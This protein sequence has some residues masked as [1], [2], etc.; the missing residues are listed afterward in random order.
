ME[1]FVLRIGHLYPEQ[2][3]LYGDRGN[4]LALVRRIQWRQIAVEVVAIDVGSQ[5]DWDSLAMVFM[6]GGEDS[7]QVHIAQD[8]LD[9]GPDLLP[10]I[11]QGMPMLAICGAYQLLGSEYVTNDG[12]HLPGLGFLDVRTE[13]GKSRQIGDVVCQVE[14]VSLSPSTLVGFENHGGMT[15]LG[16]EATAL[17]RVQTGSGNNGMDGT[18][19]AVRQHVIGTYLHGSLLP[20]NPHLADLL[21]RWA[22]DYRG[23]D[24]VLPEL[25]D[26]WEGEAHQAMVNRANGSRRHR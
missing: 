24:A 10:R 6:G 13:P 25:S 9:R 21:I 12:K 18:E 11:S 17:A 15:T 1:D 23:Q 14:G 19:G 8:F 22:L 2:M 16:R 4:V 20:K 26:V 7:H 3:N 5:V